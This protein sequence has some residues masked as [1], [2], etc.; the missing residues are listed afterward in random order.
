MKKTLSIVLSMI[1]LL[2]VVPVG[3]IC[4]SAAEDD[5]I[6]I[7]TIA[8]LYSIN[9]N[10]GGNY[11]LM[12]DIDMTEDT[13]VGG[14]WDFMGNGWEPIGSDGIYGNIPFTGTF[15]GNGYQ[16]I[17]MRSEAKVMPQGTGVVYVGLFSM[18]Q[19][20]IKNLG[21]EG[22][23]I[24]GGSSA[25]Y[26]GS[27]CAYNEGQITD[28]YYT[29]T[30]N[31]KKYVGGICGYSKCE[32]I[33]NCYN[34]GK[35]AA[36]STSALNAVYAGGIVGFCD[37]QEGAFIS[38]CYHAGEISSEFNEY[39]SNS[40]S[41]Y[42]G[43][44]FG[45]GNCPL[46]GCHNTGEIS[47]AASSSVKVSNSNVS[48][49]S[50]AYAGGL[51]GMMDS[52][53]ITDSYNSGNVMTTSHTTAETSGYY[54]SGGFKQSYTSTASAYAYSGGICGLLKGAIE[55]CYNNGKITSSLSATAWASSGSAQSRY[56]DD[57]NG[58]IAGKTVEATIADCYSTGSAN[59]G[60]S[61]TD[62]SGISDCYYLSSG[63]ASNTGAKALTS[64]QLQL[65]MCMP[66][67]DFENTW[68]IDHAT[69]YQYPQLINNRQE[70]LSQTI[71]GDVDGDGEVTII[72]VTCIQRHLVD[73]PVKAY[74][75]AAADAD[76]DGIVTIFDATLI[77]RL[78]I[79]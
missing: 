45:Y 64:A 54:T 74:N 42:A 32:S 63:G 19:G 3:T 25:N 61:G 68:V 10:L 11:R 30:M 6:E 31:G 23:T 41:A 73:I 16:I 55:R 71:I 13:A 65:E 39:T 2:T 52:N 53:T 76:G 9:N 12:N 51:C 48:S 44:I 37:Y 21:I 66:K 62:S 77:Q 29:G 18:N 33:N 35:V 59:Y 72:D 43:G 49:Q 79:Q 57:R 78:L 46:T 26:T 58:G 15:D 22:G 8:D 24:S 5:V 34:T 75:E 69:E 38:D 50:S 27:I 4:V 40:A 20:T 1:L 36:S 17:G 47:A 7:R 56:T 14:D 67:F 70:T 28:C 60:I